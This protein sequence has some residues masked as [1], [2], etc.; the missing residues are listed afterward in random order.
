MP[1]N[2][3]AGGTLARAELEALAKLFDRFEY[4][5]DPLS[6]AC[7][8]AEARF[9]AEIR[10][11]YEERV[12]PYHPQVSWRVFHAHVRVWCRAYLRKNQ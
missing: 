1:E 8:E 3:A 6:L 9:D 10:R 5:L 11:L 2:P 4:A 12:Q 7:R